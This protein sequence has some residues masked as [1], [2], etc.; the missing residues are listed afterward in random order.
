MITINV[1]TLCLKEKASGY[2]KAKGTGKLKPW[3]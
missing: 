1:I 3:P 2:I